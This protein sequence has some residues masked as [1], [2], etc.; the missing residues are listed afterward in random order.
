M[1]F[2]EPNACVVLIVFVLML[3]SIILALAAAYV[4]L[5]KVNFATKEKRLPQEQ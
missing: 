1:W 5:K 4:A 3:P 2:C